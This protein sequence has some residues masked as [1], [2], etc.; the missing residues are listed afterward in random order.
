MSFL[1]ARYQ[2]FIACLKEA[3]DFV[4]LDTSAVGQYDEVL[5]DGL[6]DVTCFVCR[7]GKTPKTA[8]NHLNQLAAEARLMSPVMV[9]NLG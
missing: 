5:V 8:I 7:S 3:Y 1:Q 9:L 4:I 2:R 6:A